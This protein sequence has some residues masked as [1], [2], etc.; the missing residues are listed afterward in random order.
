MPPRPSPK[1]AVGTIEL[2][3]ANQM[4]YHT[5]PARL[6]LLPSVKIQSKRLRQLSPRVSAFFTPRTI[7][8]LVPQVGRHDVHRS[9][10]FGA[11][12]TSLS[13]SVVDSSISS[14]K[15]VSKDSPNVPVRQPL[16]EAND[17]F[18]TEEEITDSRGGVPRDGM[19]VYT[20]GN[21]VTPLTVTNG[22]FD[23]TYDDFISTNEGD[24]ILLSAWEVSLVPLKPDADPTGATTGV[25]EMVAVVV[26][27][28][29]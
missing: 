2:N 10:R 9:S 22:F 3:L 14:A 7:V 5:L 25:H 18:L 13:D 4:V 1:R 6:L 24:R 28:K 27:M 12:S 29:Y 26:R 8:G 20:T 15:P 23:A 17:W 11:E 19:A 16:L 21:K